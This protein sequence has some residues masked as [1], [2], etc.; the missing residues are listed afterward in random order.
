MVNY[1]KLRVNLYNRKPNT[2]VL[3]LEDKSILDIAQK[4]A[5]GRLLYLR[6]VNI[7]LPLPRILQ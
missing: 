3:L 4:M 5:Q 1:L 7:I 6:I 2:Q